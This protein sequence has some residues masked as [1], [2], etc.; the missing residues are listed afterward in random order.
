MLEVFN[1]LKTNKINIS[2]SACAFKTG[3]MTTHVT[4]PHFVQLELRSV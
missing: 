4:C 1:N 3:L 2:Y